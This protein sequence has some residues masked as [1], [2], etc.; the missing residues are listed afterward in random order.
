VLFLPD[1]ADVVL[2]NEQIRLLVVPVLYTGYAFVV[3]KADF[4]LLVHHS[5]PIALG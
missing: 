4:V 2:V 5:L 1:L 3:D